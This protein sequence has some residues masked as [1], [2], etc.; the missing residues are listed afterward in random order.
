MTVVDTVYIRKLYRG[1]GHASSMLEDIVSVLP[2]QNIGFS[3]PI[4][5]T[6]GKGKHIYGRSVLV[7]GFTRLLISFIWLY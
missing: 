6:F 5:D 1:Q 7:C 2:G 4:S 3:E